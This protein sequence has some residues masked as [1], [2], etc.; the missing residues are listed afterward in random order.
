MSRFLFLHSRR[1]AYKFASVE[2]FDPTT[3]LTES[4]LSLKTP[5]ITMSRNAPT[6]VTRTMSY[7]PYTNGAP[8]SAQDE[9]TARIAS[10][11]SRIEP[12]APSCDSETAPRKTRSKTRL[13]KPYS[14]PEEQRHPSHGSAST[15][16]VT[17][18]GLR[19]TRQNIL[20]LRSAARIDRRLRILPHPLENPLVSDLI[21]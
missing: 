13:P 10:W 9:F 16:E 20:D 17:M 7:E 19:D 18:T 15:D 4:L 14:R 12:L 3:H 21:C 5:E 8:K 6:V 11:L 2:S 1:T